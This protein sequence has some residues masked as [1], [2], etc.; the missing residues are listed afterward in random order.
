MSE[1]LF[2]QP[3]EV[4]DQVGDKLW[5]RVQQFYCPQC[6]HVFWGYVRV[7]SEIDCPITEQLPRLGGGDRQTCGKPECLEK[8]Q[9]YQRRRRQAFAISRRTG[10]SR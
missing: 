8:E 2:S 4:A 3:G 10:G 6:G 1:Q 7:G 5:A 9:G